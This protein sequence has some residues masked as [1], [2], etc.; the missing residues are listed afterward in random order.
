MIDDFGHIIHIDF[1]FIF[2]WSPGK[3]MGFENADFKLTKEFID[4][5]GGNEKAEA[6]QLYVMRTIQAYLAV[7][8]HAIEFKNLVTLMIYSGFPCFKE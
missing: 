2:D 5:L 4:I 3:D 1:G 7:R 6:Y 8:E